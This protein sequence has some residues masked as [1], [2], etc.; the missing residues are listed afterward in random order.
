MGKEITPVLL[1]KRNKSITVL[2]AVVFFI[3]VQFS[4]EAFG[5]EVIIEQKEN[6]IVMAGTVSKKSIPVTAIW[7]GFYQKFGNGG[8]S[9][10]LINI[11]GKDSDPDGMVPMALSPNKG[12]E[13]PLSIG[14][15]NRSLIAL[16][17]F[18]IESNHDPLDIGLN[19][20]DVAFLTLGMVTLGKLNRELGNY[21]VQFPLV[22]VWIAGIAVSLKYWKRYPKVSRLTLIA[23]LILFGESMI[24]AYLNQQLPTIFQ[25][26]KLDTRQILYIYF[27]KDLI[28][29]LL[30]A[31]AWVLLIVAM[32]HW[33]SKRDK[34]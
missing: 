26:H 14:P 15:A 29:S 11:L 7:N 33:R 12:T 20:V 9:Q 1:I 13:S 22:I 17:N 16:G 6:R 8:V 34:G 5:Q 28:Q 10:R 3:S 19:R 31:A 4:R 24:D 25:Q 23:I 21:L 30:I 32:F 18:N 2:L 27:I